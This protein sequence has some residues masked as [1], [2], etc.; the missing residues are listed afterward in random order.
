[1]DYLIALVGREQWH[2][3]PD[4]VVKKSV[5]AFGKALAIMQAESEVEGMRYKKMSKK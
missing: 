4:E 2:M 3:H 5:D 1:M